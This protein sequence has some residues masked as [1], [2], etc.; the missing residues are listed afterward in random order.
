M[1]RQVIT[2]RDV[3]A[4][5]PSPGALMDMGGPM[6]APGKAPAE[7]RKADEWMDRLIK[8]VPSEVIAVYMGSAAALEQ[9]KSEM[10]S[11]ALFVAVLLI[12]PAYLAT[13]GKVKRPKQLILSSLCFFVWAF[14]LRL[15][16]FAGVDSAVVAAVV[17][18]FTLTLPLWDRWDSVDDSESDSDAE[19]ESQA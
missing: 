7:R 18:V 8:Y 17:P 2:A 19:S 13:L 16:P 14:A 11:W 5:G 10:L 9:V 1:G 4:A 3:K 6:G 12:T 15:E